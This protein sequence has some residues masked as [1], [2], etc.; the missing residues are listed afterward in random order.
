MKHGM[1]K[2]WELVQGW[3]Y[4]KWKVEKKWK[5]ICVHVNNLPPKMDYGSR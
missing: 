4:I 5:I 3:K 1:D 2:K